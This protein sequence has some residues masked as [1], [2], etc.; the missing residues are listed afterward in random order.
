MIG[1]IC[2]SPMTIR[3]IINWKESIK[4]G[5]MLLR[6]IADLDATYDMTDIDNI[7]INN[8]LKII[9]NSAK[10]IRKKTKRNKIK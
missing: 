1:A 7:K 10:K 6:D 4:E 8:T 5:T 3:S 2:E 9:E